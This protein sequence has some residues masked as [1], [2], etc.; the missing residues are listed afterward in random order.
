MTMGKVIKKGP[1]VSATPELVMLKPG[2]HPLDAIRMT[3]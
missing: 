1:R 2:N 3:G